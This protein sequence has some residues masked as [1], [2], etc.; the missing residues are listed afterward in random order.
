MAIRRDILRCVVQLSPRPVFP[1]TGYFGGLARTC[2]SHFYAGVSTTPVEMLVDDNQPDFP[3]LQ[4]PPVGVEMW[5]SISVTLAS[6]DSRGRDYGYSPGES[7]MTDLGF[8]RA[9][10]TPV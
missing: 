8:P 6:K 3:R 9:N 2:V 7:S 10:C 1:A 5:P 4:F